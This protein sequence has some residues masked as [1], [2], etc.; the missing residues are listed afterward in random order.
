MAKKKLLEFSKFVIF[1]FSKFFGRRKRSNSDT[2][3]RSENNESLTIGGVV[4]VTYGCD[5][6]SSIIE[7]PL[8]FCS[9]CEDFMICDKCWGKK[10]TLNH[11]HAFIVY[12]KSLYI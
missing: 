7:G 12:S 4:S 6:C 2:S 3:G 11:P 10:E 5:V 9:D 1:M 8:Y